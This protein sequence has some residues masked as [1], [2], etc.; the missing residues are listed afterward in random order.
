M[1]YTD[2]NDL[3]V[4]DIDSIK[5]VKRYVTK[6]STSVS[7]SIDQG[8]FSVKSVP[9]SALASLDSINIVSGGDG[10]KI[11][12]VVNFDNTGTTG[13]GGWWIC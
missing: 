11:G 1:T 5:G 6:D 9:S 3:E 4:V 7:K 8:A 10:Y 12:D 2:F 13:F